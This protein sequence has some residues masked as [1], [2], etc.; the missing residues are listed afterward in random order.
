MRFSWQHPF[1]WPRP[2]RYRCSNRLPPIQRYANRC[3]IAVCK[4]GTPYVRTHQGCVAYVCTQQVRVFQMRLVQVR[5]GQSCSRQVCLWPDQITP[6]QLPIVRQSGWFTNNTTRRDEVQ[7][8]L[9]KVRLVQVRASQ[10]R[11]PQARR[12][13]GYSLQDCVGQVCIL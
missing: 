2:V 13:V 3:W 8:C 4:G 1:R 11:V 12:I 6:S 7:R 5:T 10:I 9:H